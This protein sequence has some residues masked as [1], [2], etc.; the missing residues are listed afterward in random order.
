MRNDIKGKL[1]VEL[2]K[3]IEGEPQVIYILSRI[4]KILEIDKNKK[5]NKQG[6]KPRK[7]SLKGVNAYPDAERIK[8]THTEYKS[9]DPCPKCPEGRLYLMATWGKIIKFLGSQFLYVIIYLQEKLRCNTCGWIV[10]AQLPP[11]AL[12]SKANS[13]AQA[14]I[15]LLKY[16]AGFPF[17]RMATIQKYLKT[18][19]SASSLW[20]MIADLIEVVTIIWPRLRYYAAQGELL[21]NDDTTNKILESMKPSK[22]PNKK[23]KKTVYTSGILSVLKDGIKI[24]LFFTGENHA[25]KNLENLL[26]ERESSLEKPIHMSDASSMNDVKA[27]TNKGSCLTHIRRYF[28]ECYSKYKADATHFITEVGKVYAIDAETKKLSKEDRLLVHQEK[29]GPIMAELYKWMTE[30]LAQNLVEPNSALGEAIAHALKHWDKATLFL[31]IAGA[32]L[33]ND[34]LEQ[35]FKTVKL[36]VKNAMFYKTQWGALVGDIFMS[37]IHTTVLAN[38][39]PYEY[40]VAILDNKTEVLKNPDLWMPWNF[41]KQIEKSSMVA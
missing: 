35:K 36:S 33:S 31:R 16:A 41:R 27:E 39:N 34:E 15:A 1:G 12:G 5:K 7:S 24:I 6:K 26:L 22:D 23:T 18:P 2:G 4:R 19:T 10:A 9:G 20:L 17:Y 25:G 3:D 11:E 32:P 28:V 38:E 30:R 8:V 40:L 13:E 14:M 37:I 29:S 21:H